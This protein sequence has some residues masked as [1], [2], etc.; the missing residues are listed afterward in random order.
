MLARTL[1]LKSGADVAHMQM[2]DVEIISVPKTDF[3]IVKATSVRV[4]DK[5]CEIHSAKIQEL[6]CMI[7]LPAEETVRHY[8]VSITSVW[9]VPRW[10]YQAH[11]HGVPFSLEGGQIHLR[12]VPSVWKTMN[13]N[14]KQIEQE[15]GV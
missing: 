7:R 10:S 1:Q 3:I 6:G 14:V 5:F 9:S 15:S 2:I 13:T 12:C 11:V 4:L 8:S